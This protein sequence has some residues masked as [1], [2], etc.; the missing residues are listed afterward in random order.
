MVKKHILHNHVISYSISV[1][2][3]P[4]ALLIVLKYLFDFFLC[5]NPYHLQILLRVRSFSFPKLQMV[6]RI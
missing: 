2:F 3:G 5:Y 6:E 4:L 1:F